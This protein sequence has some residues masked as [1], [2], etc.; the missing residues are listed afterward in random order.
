MLKIEKI[1]KI[2]NGHIEV[3]VEKNGREFRAYGEYS[4]DAEGFYHGGL[5]HAP[6]QEDMDVVG[7]EWENTPDAELKKQL[8]EQLL[9]L[10]YSLIDND[11]IFYGK[12]NQSHRCVARPDGAIYT[13]SNT[14]PCDGLPR[15]IYQGDHVTLF[16]IP[17]GFAY[18]KDLIKFCQSNEKEILAMLQGDDFYEQLTEDF[19]YYAENKCHCVWQPEDYYQGCDI[20][21]LYKESGKSMDEFINSEIEDARANGP[22]CLFYSDL[23][24]YLKEKLEEQAD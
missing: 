16:S 8:D 23:E 17:N 21:D 18:G 20:I 3:V 5:I 24:K 12:I 14:G 6:S 10:S 9:V 7:A 1:E 4:R 19:H 11:E 15:E 2:E 22:Y 13:Y